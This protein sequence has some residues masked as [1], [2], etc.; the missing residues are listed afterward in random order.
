[1]SGRSKGYEAMLLPVTRIQRFST[2]DGPGIRSTVFLQGC[3]LHCLWCHN[4]E[5]LAARPQILFSPA[6]CIGCGACVKICPSHAQY[7]EPD[8]SHH[9]RVQDCLGCLRCTQVCP[10]HA[11]EPASRPMSLEE[12]WA[13][14]LRDKP[15]YGRDGGMTLSGGEPLLYPAGCL[16][17]L[18]MARAARITSVIE[19]SGFFDTSFIKPLAKL[20][21]L[22][23]WDFKD[24]DPRRHLA[25]TG[26]ASD[27]I[28]SNLFLLDEQETKIIL[29]SVMVKGI[30]LDEIHIAA[31]ASVACRLNKCIGIELLP[32]HPFGGSKRAQLGYENDGRIE[33]IPTPE[34]MRWARGRLAQIMQPSSVSIMGG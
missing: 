8:G 5:S 2:H 30:N 31:L 17:L 22:F 26:V 13:V 3:P 34:D 18:E 10:A 16:G 15:F 20:T 19:T 1:L 23:L 4:P 14:V 12:I 7:F 32:Y 21:S 27:Q 9:F 29:R 28:L 11:V 6:R 25:N 33:W 24:G